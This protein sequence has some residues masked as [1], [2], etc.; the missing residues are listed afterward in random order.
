M[1]IQAVSEH[2][3]GLQQFVVDDVPVELNGSCVLYK[4]VFFKSGEHLS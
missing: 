2:G 4:T 1:S 3:K